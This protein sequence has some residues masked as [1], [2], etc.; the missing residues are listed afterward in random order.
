MRRSGRLELHLRDHHRPLLD[1]TL[2]LPQI[3]EAGQRWHNVS[4]S[5]LKP[6]LEPR[7]A[8]LDLSSR[9]TTAAGL[10][11]C[12][13]LEPNASDI[14]PPLQNT[15]SDSG[16]SASSEDVQSDMAKKFSDP[17]LCLYVSIIFFL[18]GAIM[19]II[20]I[21]LCKKIRR[22]IAILKVT[23]PSR[24]SSAPASAHYLHLCFSPLIS[25]P[26]PWLGSCVR[27]VWCHN[28]SD[29]RLVR[30]RSL[31]FAWKPDLIL[32]FFVLN[33]KHINTAVLIQV[34]YRDTFR[35]AHIANQLCRHV[36]VL[37]LVV[38][39]HHL[40]FRMRRSLPNSKTTAL[41]PVQVQQPDQISLL[42]QLP[43]IPLEL[44]VPHGRR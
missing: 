24:A 37:H 36:P 25:N 12:N 32:H 21:C 40:P 14:A 43:L 33:T 8:Q 19:I 41:R 30:P 39:G 20:V 26:L 2:L 6:S 7:G 42:V 13:I 4:T 18:L 27:G 3:H 15:S 28:H 9:P 29:V 34:H 5:A 22:A 44:H 10:V 11:R 31:Y 35:H 23:A 38:R 1:G 17:N 16:S